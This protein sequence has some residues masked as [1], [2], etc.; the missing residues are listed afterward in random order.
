MVANEMRY[1]KTWDNPEDTGQTCDLIVVGGGL[2]GLTVA[3]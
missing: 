3:Y 2:S 1:G